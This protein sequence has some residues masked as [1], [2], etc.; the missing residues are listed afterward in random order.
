MKDMTT[1]SPIKNIFLFAIPVLLGNLFQNF[2]AIADSVIVGQLLGVEALAAVGAT[3]SIVFLVFGWIVGLTSGFGILISQAYGAG[4]EWYLKH[5]VAMSTYICLIFTIVMTVG[6]LTCNDMILHA[7]NIP[8]NILGDTS[9]YICIIYM[10]IPISF[11]YNMLTSIARALGDSKTPLYFL[12]LSSV[13]NIGLDFLLV[14]KTPLGVAG[15]AYATLIAQLVSAILCFI[16]VFRKYK[17]IHF[18]KEHSKINMQSVKKLLGMG[19]PMGLQFS[20]TAIGVMIVQSSLN[21]LGAI[22]IAAFAAA[23]KIQNILMQVYIAMGAAVAT[24]VGQNFGAGKIERIKKGVRQS[25]ITGLILTVFLMLFSYYFAGP[26]TRVF[27]TDN[28]DDVVEIAKQ[29]LH[30][31]LWFYPWLGMIF[32]YRN[33]LQ[34]LGNGFMPMMGGVAE[35]IARALIVMIFF[36]ELQFVAICMSEA[37]AWVSALIPLI[38]YYYYYTRKLT[39]K[40]IS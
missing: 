16:Y 1:G 39:K 25:V 9:V 10:S 35:L 34:G 4:D 21:T 36:E 22:Y 40:M 37:I 29:Y 12:T 17:E 28:A 30:I 15:A 38:P 3:S 24:Y 11:I 18:A 33:A 27:V 5:Y 6:L 14:A 26:L 31:C 20:I 8:E 23:I 7:M 2:Y 13:I 32:T 19:V